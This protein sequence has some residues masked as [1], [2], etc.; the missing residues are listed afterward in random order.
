M[1]PSPTKERVRKTCAEFAAQYALVETAIERLFTQYPK[2]TDPA[3]VLAKVVVLNQLYNSRVLNIHLETLAKHIV[4]CDLDA[5][6]DALSL[7]AVDLIVSCEG[8]RHYYSF[9]TKYCSWHRPDFYPIMDSYVNQALWD[10]RRTDG[11][12]VFKR[13]DLE[14]YPEFVRIVREFRTH[15]G[16]EEFSL[17][18]I[19]EC[20]WM[21]GQ[22][23]V[24]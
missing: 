14:R 5:H 21:W 4:S 6:F 13:Q 22:D 19:D 1:L 15:F 7:D 2:N 3:E 8:I 11:F 17:K 16:L 18:Q 10:Y 20:L 23:S 9:A 24:L 12:A